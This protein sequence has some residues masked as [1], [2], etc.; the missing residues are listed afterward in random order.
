MLIGG[1]RHLTLLVDLQI[2]ASFSFMYNTPAKLGVT[3]MTIAMQRI[4][5]NISSV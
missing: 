3:M 5:A 4:A 1:D 2:N